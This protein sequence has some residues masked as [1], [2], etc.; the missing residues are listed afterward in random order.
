MSAHRDPPRSNAESISKQID[1]FLGF[2]LSN[3]TQGSQKLPKP[4]KTNPNPPNIPTTT[5]RG[6]LDGFG[7]GFG[8]FGGGGFGEL[9][10]V[11]GRHGFQYGPLWA[12]VCSLVDP[13]EMSEAHPTTS[14]KCVLLGPLGFGGSSARVLGSVLTDTLVAPGPWKLSETAPGLLFRSILAFLAPVMGTIP[15]SRRPRPRR[16]RREPGLWSHPRRQEAMNNK[17][18]IGIEDFAVLVVADLPSPKSIPRIRLPR[19]QNPGRSHVFFPAGAGL[20]NS[21]PC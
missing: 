21:L 6:V 15:G 18:V 20:P 3:E 13:Q 2:Q 17:N 19:P 5:A 12:A 14:R 9:W 7:E 16:G 10:G 11:L 4:T 8:V 1:L